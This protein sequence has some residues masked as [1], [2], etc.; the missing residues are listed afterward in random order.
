MSQLYNL[1]YL[2]LKKKNLSI[3]SRWKE[4]SLVELITPF[5]LSSSVGLPL[6]LAEEQFRFGICPHKADR[7]GRAQYLAHSSL[8]LE[9]AFLEEEANVLKEGR[10]F[11]M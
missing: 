4:K 9:A 6:Y 2:N 8:A 11:P 5:P 3:F 1:L 10:Y 7:E